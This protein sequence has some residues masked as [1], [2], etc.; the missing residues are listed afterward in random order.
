MRASHIRPVSLIT[1]LAL[2]AC[3]T[4]PAPREPVMQ[5][6]PA[7]PTLA[8]TAAA[9]AET[10][11]TPYYRLVYAPALRADATLLAGTLDAAIQAWRT[12]YAGANADALLRAAQVEIRLAAAPD[13]SCGVGHATN[14]SSWDHGHCTATIHL[15]APSAHPDPTQ[16]G[17]PRTAMDEPQDTAYC[18]RVLVHEYSTVLLESITRSKAAGWSFWNAPAWFVQGAEEYLGVRYST[19]H[20]WQIT[21]RKYVAATRQGA[22]VSNDFGLDV[23]SPYVAGPVVIAFIHERYGRDAF[24]ALLRSPAPS[25]GRALRETLKVTPD[26]FYAAFQTWLAGQAAE[27]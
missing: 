10:I 25:F 9:Q 7:A 24:I 13:A 11:A 27:S 15:L 14:I 12:D 17:A 5:A 19:P 4:P 16:P 26:Q 1:L 6:P 18:Q 3:A 21:L 23:Q 22:L 2:G 8:Q 20:A